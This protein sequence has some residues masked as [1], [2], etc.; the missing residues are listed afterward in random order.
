MTKLLPFKDP[1]R[2]CLKVSQWP[3]LDQD[4]WHALFLPGDILDGSVGAGFHWKEA[5]REKYRKGYGRWL[6]FLMTIRQLDPNTPP[7]LRVTP[8]YIS[9]YMEKLH[10]DEIADWTVWGR[11]NELLNVM[12]AMAPDGDWSWLRRIVR[13]IEANSHDRRNKLQRLR[14]APEIAAWAYKRM[15][16]LIANP[17]RRDPASHFR[18]AMMISLLITCPTM[19]LRNLTMIELQRHLKRH[20][21]GY[22][23]YFSGNET[24]TAKPMSI[25][26][27]TS[28]TP[29]LDHYITTVRPHLLLGA[30]SPRLWITR[31]G[32]PMRDKTIFD[33]I[34]TVTERAFGAPINPHLFRDCA[35]TTVA[36]QDPEHAGIAAPLLA[37]TDPRTTEKHY[38]QANSLAAG[39]RLRQSVDALRNAHRL[40][41]DKK[42]RRNTGGSS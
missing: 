8:E 7:A 13:Y 10:D 28:L 39:R 32:G 17:P 24:K 14:P 34:T 15:D 16:D 42:P 6:T 33:R 18:D 26:V 21:H 3:E 22:H 35:V 9:I 30:H 41:A 40:P 12:K 36:I 38:I 19:R 1:T 20:E 11:L 2:R 31:Y 27:P 37:H 4:A 25:P 5:T 29:Y 23:L